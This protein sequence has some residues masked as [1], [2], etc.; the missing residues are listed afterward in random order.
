MKRSVIFSCLFVFAV[1]SIGH[2]EKQ[3]DPVLVK[4]VD[5]LLDQKAIRNAEVSILLAHFAIRSNSVL[6]A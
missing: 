4:A 2:A 3:G 6:Q 5:A 1:A